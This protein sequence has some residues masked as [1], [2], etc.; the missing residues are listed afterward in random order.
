[1]NLGLFA[2]GLDLMPDLGYPPVQFGGWD[3]PRAN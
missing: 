3:S 1:M 2:R